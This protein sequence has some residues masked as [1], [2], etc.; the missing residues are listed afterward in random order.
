YFRIPHVPHPVITDSL[1]TFFAENPGLFEENIQYRFRNRDQFSAIF[2][3]NYL[4]ISRQNAV[5][6]DAEDALML[7]GE[8]DFLPLINL[9]LKKIKDDR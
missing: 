9:K 4:E 1:K 7:N 3:A 6:R 5:L 2:L 8:I